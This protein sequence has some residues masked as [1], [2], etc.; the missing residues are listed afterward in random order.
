MLYDL[1]FHLNLGI[2]ISNQLGMYTIIT[3]FHLLKALNPFFS[4]NYTQ[5]LSS[6]LR[7][8]DL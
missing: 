6:N 3:F 7:L 5:A 1:V 2:G 4:M 8:M